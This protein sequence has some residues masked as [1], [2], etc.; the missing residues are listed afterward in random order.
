MSLNKF[1]KDKLFQK[2]LGI[3]LLNLLFSFFFWLSLQANFSLIFLSNDDLVLITARILLTL[4]LF[5]L[6]LGLY[7]LSAILIK[8]WQAQFFLSLLLNFPYLFFFN[9]SSFALVGFLILVLL[10]FLWG[11][12]LQRFARDWIQPKIFVISRA[13]LNLFI[14][15]LLLVIAFSFYLH[16]LYQGRTDVLLPK[17]EKVEIRLVH[18]SF[19]LASSQYRPEMTVDEFSNLVIKSSLGQKLF[20]SQLKKTQVPEGKKPYFL[21]ELLAQKL[22]TKLSGK[23]TMDFLVSTF[24]RNYITL[25]F[26]KYKYLFSGA[27]AFVL[28][29]FLKIFSPLYRVL[30]R[31]FA[32]MWFGLFLRLKTIHFE[33]QE[34]EIK[35]VVL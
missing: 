21:R 34:R 13:G 26:Q 30:V 20:A 5:T 4:L 8:T 28:F 2:I 31:S 27:T 23:E 7:A 14:T 16:L 6:F 1:F 22:A 10:F 32:L 29:L 19:R 18:T 33:V 25:Y 11:L 3:F 15:G 35:R 12:R 24:V 17:L 9:F